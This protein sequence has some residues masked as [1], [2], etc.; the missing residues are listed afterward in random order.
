[1]PDWFSY[2]FTYSGP[3]RALRGFLDAITLLMEAGYAVAGI[4]SLILNLILPEESEKGEVVTPRQD[5]DGRTTRNLEEGYTTGVDT[6]VERNS[7]STGSDEKVSMPE[8]TTSK[9][10]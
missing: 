3:N 2:F 10:E 6:V 5:Y 1:M 4:I 7:I 8:G 9:Q